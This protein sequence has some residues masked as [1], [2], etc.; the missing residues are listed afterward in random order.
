MS[1]LSPYHR[2]VSFKS[3][4]QQN[5]QKPHNGT[6]LDQELDLISLSMANLALALKDIRRDDGQLKNSIV[7]GDSLAPDLADQ[8]AGNVRA[9]LTPLQQTVTAKADQAT[10]SSIQAQAAADQAHT[11]EQQSLALAN[12]SGQILSDIQTIKKQIDIKADQSEVTC[13]ASKAAQQ[14]SVQAAEQAESY[15]MGA[16]T[17]FAD[18][19]KAAETAMDAV[20]PSALSLTKSR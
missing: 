4:S 7:T 19:Q 8:L 20:G 17:A 10:V 2:D 11:S 6:D 5:P 9:E 12:Q 18:A 16:E 1:S 13:Q 14:A 3:H 15:Q